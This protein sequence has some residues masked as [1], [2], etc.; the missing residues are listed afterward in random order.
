MGLHGGIDKG[1]SEAPPLGAVPAG[2]PAQ[3]ALAQIRWETGSVILDGYFGHA[4][5]VPDFYGNAAPG[6]QMVQGVVQQIGEDPV[7]EGDIH[8]HQY[9]LRGLRGQVLNS[10]RELRQR[11]HQQGDR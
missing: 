10:G 9:R 4:V 6:G 3:R 11:L 1:Q 7:H 2:K 5:A 8:L